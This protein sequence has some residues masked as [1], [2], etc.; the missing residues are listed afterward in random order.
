MTKGTTLQAQIALQNWLSNRWV[1]QMGRAVLV[2]FFLA[3]LAAALHPTLRFEA[4]SFLIADHRSVVSTVHGDLVGDGSDFTIVKVKTHENLFLEIYQPLANGTT[5]L[6]SRIPLADK[7]DGYFSFNGQATNLA[8][9][10]VDG[11][12]SSE[13]IAPSFDQNL[14][15]HLNVFKYDPTSKDFHR[16]LN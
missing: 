8:I 13:I 5:K 12:G 1:M 3:A 6:V 11:D 14:V 4:R 16:V 10:N 15:G 7:K 2:A 9:A